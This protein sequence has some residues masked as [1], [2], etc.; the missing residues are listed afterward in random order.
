MATTTSIDRQRHA[1]R[2]AFAGEQAFDATVDLY[3]TVSAPRGE[4]DAWQQARPC[5][6]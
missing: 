3:T 1:V 2:I 5:C 4:R 6:R